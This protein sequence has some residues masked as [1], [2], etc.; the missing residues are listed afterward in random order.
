MGHLNW[1]RIWIKLNRIRLNALIRI[2]NRFL[3][4]I[5]VGLTGDETG[6]VL[7]EVRWCGF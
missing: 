2:V 5:D 6:L 1:F 7:K 4:Q 3:Q